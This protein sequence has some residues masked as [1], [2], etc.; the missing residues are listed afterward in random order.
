MT[1]IP[2]V[3]IIIILVVVTHITDIAHDAIVVVVIYA[4][5]IE[6]VVA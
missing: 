6:V 3:E 5:C 1:H 2:G 4:T